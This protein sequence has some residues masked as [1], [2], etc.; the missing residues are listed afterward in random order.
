MPN[1]ILRDYTDSY[2]VNQLSA[3]AECLFIRLLTKVDDFG[4]FTADPSVL[5]ASAYP[6]RVANLTPEFIRDRL[7]ECRHAGLVDIYEVDGKRYLTIERFRNVPR[8]KESKYPAKGDS[9]GW[10][11]RRLRRKCRARAS[12]TKTALETKTE[13]KTAPPTPQRGAR[14]AGGGSSFASPSVEIEEDEADGTAEP[15]LAAEVAALLNRQ[16]GCTPPF[17]AKQVIACLPEDFDRDDAFAAAADYVRDQRASSFAAIYPAKSFRAF[18]LRKRA[19]AEEP[20]RRSSSR[21]TVVHEDPRSRPIL[22]T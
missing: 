5:L 13:K 21:R 19:K 14:G 9:P 3:D 17:T 18:I 4:R 2:R 15:G 6:L 11:D 20:W 8:A 12:E 1:R 22:G 16:L 7:E 10:Q